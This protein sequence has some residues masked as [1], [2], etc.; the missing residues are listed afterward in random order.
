VVANAGVYIGG[1]ACCSRF[2]CE[3]FDRK[4]R[5]E[6]AMAADNGNAND[7]NTSRSGLDD[8]KNRADEREV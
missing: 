4:S 2:D 8:T 5:R 6:N 7:V 3:W 1:F